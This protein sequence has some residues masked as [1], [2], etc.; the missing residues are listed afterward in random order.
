MQKKTISSKDLH[1][2]SDILKKYIDPHKQSAF[3]F[4]SAA[5]KKMRRS[6]DVDIGIEGEDISSEA[7]FSIKQDLEDSNLPFTVDVVRFSQVDERF[8]EIAKKDIIPLPLS[9]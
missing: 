5:T 2:I 4:G 7:Y 3:I 9:L 6:S 8:K 1:S